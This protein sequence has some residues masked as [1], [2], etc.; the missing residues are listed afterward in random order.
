MRT[1]ILALGGVAAA[2]MLLSAGAGPAVAGA[3]PKG[4]SHTHFNAGAPGDPKKPFRVIE[5]TALEGSG[6]MAFDPPRIQVVKGEQIKFVIKNDGALDHEFMLDTVEANAKHA[7]EMEK[8]PEM[9]HDDPNGKRVQPKKAA[10]L[11]WRFT[12]LG[13]FEYACMIPG[14]YQAGMKGV[15]EVVAPGKTAK[16]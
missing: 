8:N 2:A 6:T 10:E 11:I 4:H 12:K 15:V 7:K 16:K 14:H 5:V 9:E 3:G 13:T 1:T